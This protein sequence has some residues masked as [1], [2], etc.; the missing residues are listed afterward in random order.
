MGQSSTLARLALPDDIGQG[1]R[2]MKR[3]PKSERVLES[4]YAPETRRIAKISLEITRE[5]RVRCVVSWIIHG[6]GT[7]VYQPNG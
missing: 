1:T 5:Y 6:I 7:A 2:P 4:V 3:Q